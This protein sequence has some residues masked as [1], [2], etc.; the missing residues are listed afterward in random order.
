MSVSKIVITG[1]VLREP[2]KRF[3]ESN[4]T[5]TSFT[6]NFGY[7]NQEKVIRVFSLGKTA[8]RIAEDVKKG[9]TIVV[10][11]RLQTNSVKTDAGADKKYFEIN[12]QNIEI[13]EK[14][15]QTA[16]SSSGGKND[17][18]NLNDEINS[19]DLIGE[20]EIPF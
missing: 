1:E 13:V 12:A 15:A 20:D 6:M 18:F 3:T 10:E 19:D 7:D 11:G 16:V 5:I 2:E 9:Q 8:E 17:E 4:L 14:Q